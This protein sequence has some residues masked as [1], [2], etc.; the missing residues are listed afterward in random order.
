MVSHVWQA[1]NVRIINEESL[2]SQR[3]ESPNSLV[4]AT[5]QN[6]ESSEKLTLQESYV[7]GGDSKL[8]SN[9]TLNEIGKLFSDFDLK[10]IGI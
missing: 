4:E 9:N 6:P 2:L 8:S 10:L 1:L 7:S 3:D 5:D